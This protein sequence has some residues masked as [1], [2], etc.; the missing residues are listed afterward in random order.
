MRPVREPGRAARSPLSGRIAVLGSSLFFLGAGLL[1][2]RMLHD[3]W[4]S[5]RA[6]AAARQAL[7]GAAPLPWEASD[8]ADP[9]AAACPA[10]ALAA[11]AVSLIVQAA[12]EPPEVQR[13]ARLQE[14]ERR[15]ERALQARSA[16]G[17]WWV[18]LA[19]AR[20]LEGRNFPAA[21]A[22]LQRSYAA[23]PFLPQ[24]GAWRVRISAGAWSQ[25]DAKTRRALVDEAVWLTEVDPAAAAPALAAFTH[26][27]A[28][29]AL[30]AGLALRRPGLIPHR[31]SRV[32]D[33]VGPAH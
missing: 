19:Y 11:S 2:L 6:E 9:C 32:P 3:E 22:N 4:I 17:E 25:L 23:T 15:L 10:R 21:V 33:G 30:R 13:R 27:D 31:R 18:W 20:V 8:A 26:P 5:A 1:G 7:T 14:A 29:A 28:A 12:A 24:E 16:E